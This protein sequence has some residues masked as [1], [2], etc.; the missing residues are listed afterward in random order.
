MKLGAYYWDG[1]YA[2]IGHQTDR[3]MLEFPDRMPIWGWLGDTIGN[4][5]LQIDIAADAGLKFF[6]F[7]WYYSKDGDEILMNGCVD[8]YLEARNR[9][10]L[11]WCLLVANHDPFRVYKDDWV[12]FCQKVIPYLKDTYTLNVN[13]IPIIIIFSPFGLI[14]DLG[15]LEETK[16]CFATFR[17]MVKKSGLKDV[18]IV[19]GCPGIPRDEDT[20][21]VSVDDNKWIEFCKILEDAG[22]DSISGY[23]Y[24]R[25]Y[26]KK[27]DLTNLIYP[28]DKLSSDYEYAWD[29]FAQHCKLPG[30]LNVNGGWD[31]RPWEPGLE[32]TGGTATPSCYSPDRTPYTQYKHV[33]K[34]GEWQKK[35]PD[36]S[37]DGLAIVYAW[38][39]N[40]EGGY[41]QP[42]IGDQGY[43]LKAISRAIR[44]CNE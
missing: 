33:M 14:E 42:T 10:R 36:K 40:G 32:I 11:E 17:E 29:M 24:H 39:E 8:R 4:M 41:I 13:E 23:N 19:A 1:W 22:Y 34:A 27:G 25:S 5:E 2:R 35:Y 9:S 38:N 28:F 15:G 18:C 7:D 43:V 6:A 21:D 30:L 20:Q 31:C 44:E 26:I 37:L 16:K 3:L 12:K